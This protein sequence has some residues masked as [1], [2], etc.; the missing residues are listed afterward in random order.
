MARDIPERRKISDCSEIRQAR[1]SR[2]IQD[3]IR[4]S[5]SGCL[6]RLVEV[7]VEHLL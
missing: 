3:Q 4:I 1:M 6:L 7:L 5:D 2:T